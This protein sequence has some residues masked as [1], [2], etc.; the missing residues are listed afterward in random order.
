MFVPHTPEGIHRSNLI[1]MED[2]LGFRTKIKYV[3]EQGIKISGTLVKKDPNPSHCER[4]WCFTCQSKPGI[5]SRQGAVYKILCVNC[6]EYNEGQEKE[7]QEIGQE[8]CYFGE[9]ARTLFDRGQEHLK[10]LKKKSP[11]SPLW[12]HHSEAHQGQEPRFTMEAVSFTNSALIRQSMEARLIV[13][14]GHMNL[15]NRKGEWGQNLPPKLLM[16]D[17][18]HEGLG[19]CK[20]GSM[21]RSRQEPDSDEGDSNDN[22]RSRKVRNSER[23]E[24]VPEVNDRSQV[25]LGQASPGQEAT[26]PETPTASPAP[27][28]SEVVLSDFLS[29]NGPQNEVS[30]KLNSVSKVKKIVQYSVKDMYS[31]FQRQKLVQTSISSKNVGSKVE[32]MIIHNEPNYQL[33]P[34]VS[35][36]VPYKEVKMNELPQNSMQITTE[37]IVKSTDEEVLEGSLHR[38]TTN[39]F[40][41]LLDKE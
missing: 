36:N 17:E 35:L 34:K 25:I 39:I 2:S 29:E 7:G 18:R 33:K 6:K 30:D 10:A 24:T 28:L 21:K 8:T 20:S 14:N 12:E 27:V 19:Q 37:N 23:S 38:T 40:E 3:E 16:E 32:S 41:K 31:Y 1:K 15:M 13:D 26:N 5:C 4:E 9:S 11:E 22:N